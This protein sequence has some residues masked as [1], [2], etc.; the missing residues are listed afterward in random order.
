MKYK[1]LKEGE[2]FRFEGL[3][4]VR[5]AGSFSGWIPPDEDVVPINPPCCKCQCQGQEPLKYGDL[6]LGEQFRFCNFHSVGRRYMKVTGG[7][8]NS[9]LD[10]SIHFRK[11]GPEFYGLPIIKTDEQGN[12]LPPEKQV[13]S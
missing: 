13:K 5:Q 7:Y 2:L 12:D 8:V 11:Y 10:G 1:D 6:R 3:G 9:N 4:E